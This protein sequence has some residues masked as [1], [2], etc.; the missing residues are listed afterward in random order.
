MRSLRGAGLLA[1]C[2]VVACGGGNGSSA[3]RGSAAPQVATAS[4][5]APET[6]TPARGTILFLGTSLTAGLGLEAD[7]A[8]PQQIQRKIDAAKLPYRVVNAGVSGETA[9][10]LLKRL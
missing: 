1:L 7:S 5:A 10:G 8:Y 4:G 6:N 3:A 9:A 2:W